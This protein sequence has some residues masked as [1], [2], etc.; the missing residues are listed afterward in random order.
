MEQQTVGEGC[1]GEEMR[2][3]HLKILMPAEVDN[4]VATY[5]GEDG[6]LPQ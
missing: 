4:A 2:K 1:V 6:H 5:L 3:N